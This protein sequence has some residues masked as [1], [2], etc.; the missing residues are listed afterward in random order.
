[1]AKRNPEQLKYHREYMKRYRLEHEGYRIMNNAHRIEMA[2]KNIVAT[3][4]RWASWYHIKRK[5]VIEALGNK[6]A[7][8][9]E[10]EYEF[11]TLDHV[12]GGGQKH[13]TEMGGKLWSS[14]LN[15]GCPGD[16]YRVLCFNCNM[17]LAHSGYCP[18]DKQT[19]DVLGVA[20]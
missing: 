11:L 5:A 8:C 6:C 17:S 4:Q 13:R 9:G 20:C 16:K 15:E 12:K 7:C 10:T 2:K 1:M 19:F 3:R 18:H 14:I